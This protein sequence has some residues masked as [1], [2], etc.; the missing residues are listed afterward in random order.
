MTTVM[1]KKLAMVVL[2][3]SIVAAA[4]GNAKAVN[5]NGAGDGVSWEDPNN[6]TDG[7]V[8]MNENVF[9]DFGPPVF[10][11]TAVPPVNDVHV[12]NNFSQATPQELRVTT[13]GALNMANGQMK[14][15]SFNNAG[16]GAPAVL[17]LEDNAQVISR[18]GL[19][20]NPNG[21]TLTAEMHQSGTS[22]FDAGTRINWSGGPSNT[23]PI[24]LSDDAR[25]IV[26]D[27]LWDNGNFGGP[28]TDGKAVISLDGNARLLLG[29]TG[30]F[31][32]DQAL[33]DFLITNGVITAV[34]GVRHE[35]IGDFRVFSQIPEPATASLIIMAL[36]VTCSLRFQVKAGRTM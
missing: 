19:E 17:R 29:A 11:S 1:F 36:G 21:G 12:T 10:I 24:F 6:W 23:G 34:Q 7:M 32:T 33:G 4:F 28:F 18:F 15:A 30:T 5:F 26:P 20:I 8:P 35:V 3:S 16:V 27:G 2:T 22:V 9:L 25:L 13:N 31:A 14:L